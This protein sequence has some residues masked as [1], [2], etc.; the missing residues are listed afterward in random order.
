MRAGLILQETDLAVLASKKLDVALIMPAVK[1][2]EATVSRIL[3]CTA[4]NVNRFMPYGAVAP[5][6]RIT[7]R[8]IR[9]FLDTSHSLPLEAVAS[10]NDLYQYHLRLQFY[11]VEALEKA[12]CDLRPDVLVIATPPYRRY[13]SPMRPAVG[14]LHLET[15]TTAWLAAKLAGEM[16]IDCEYVGPTKLRRLLPVW[17]QQIVR[18]IL[19]EGFRALKLMQKC[20]SAQREAVPEVDRGAIAMVVRTDSEVLSAH[21]AALAL[22][23]R[24]WPVSFVHDEIL[25]SQTTLDRL[26][27]LGE[28]STPIGK[29]GGWSSLARAFATYPRRV[30]ASPHFA[31]AQIPASVAEK[32]LRSPQIWKSMARRLLDFA[33]DQRHFYLELS[34]YTDRNA[35]RALVTFAHVDQWGPVVAG[36][37]NDANIPCIAIQN[38]VQDPE[39]YPRLCWADQYCIESS[40]L[41]RRLIDLGYP[42]DRLA[43]TGLPRFMNTLPAAIQPAETRQAH[44]TIVILTQPLYE[45]YFEDLIRRSAAFAGQ[46]DWTLIIK[47]H[48]REMRDAYAQLADELASTATIRVEQQTPLEEILD[49]T[50]LVVSVVSSAM[51][52]AIFSGIPTI[53][54]LP[55]EENHLD[56]IYTSH[57]VTTTTRSQAEFES[58]LTNFG[59]RYAKHFALFQE[60]RLN[61]LSTYAVIE[62]SDD[63]TANVVGIIES[64]LI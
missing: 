11:G 6:S 24:G 40:Y 54:F 13:W 29:M 10:Q 5:A 48:P 57:P 61:Y 35:C 28:T 1:L 49:A 51:L 53:A 15:R 56:L 39:E 59:E 22:R 52:N 32:I 64:A 20:A 31:D 58:A 17:P 33:V 4:S 44:R 21:P 7:A 25:S 43:A 36:V 60:N 2:P 45:Q 55:I 23:A 34:R 19:L 27:A 30:A 47:L 18:R 38:A 8:H 37:A 16:A 42:A 9:A 62:P 14:K 46:L 26:K 50:S 3:G 12:L 41:R 63:A